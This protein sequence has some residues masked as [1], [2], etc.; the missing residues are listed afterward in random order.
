MSRS[1]FRVLALAFLGG[2]VLGGCAGS[3]STTET[4]LSPSATPWR[5]VPPVSATEIPTSLSVANVKYTAKQGDYANS[6]AA[7]AGG[8]CSG[9]EVLAANPGVTTINAGDIINVPAN[10]LGPGVTEDILNGTVIPDTAPPQESKTTTT[11]RESY[12]VYVVKSGDFW[13][14]IA[15]RTGCTYRQLKAANPGVTKLFPKQELNVP[16]SCDTRKN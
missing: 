15:R 14:R 16:K 5:T 2:A 1:L 10:C 13:V 3:S 11:A 8:G 6:I 4:T 9:A 7:T 12:N